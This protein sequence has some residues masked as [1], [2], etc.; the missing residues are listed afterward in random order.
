MRIAGP[1]RQPGCRDVEDT[2]LL[3]RDEAWSLLRVLERDVD[4]AEKAGAR[5]DDAAD[6]FRMVARKLLP[7]LFPDE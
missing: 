4:R 2:I 6:A 5:D 1:R 7:D 3:T